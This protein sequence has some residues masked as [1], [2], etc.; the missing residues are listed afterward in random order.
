MLCYCAESHLNC[1]FLLYVYCI[2]PM[3]TPIYDGLFRNAVFYANL[4]QNFVISTYGHR[5]FYQTQFYINNVS[6]IDF[7]F[8]GTEA[9]SQSQLIME[10]VTE[11]ELSCSRDRCFKHGTLTY[12]SRNIATSTHLEFTREESCSHCIK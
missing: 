12:Q 8:T 3:D 4:S 5:N 2:G 11:I 9:L 6:K 7:A 1:L 10:N